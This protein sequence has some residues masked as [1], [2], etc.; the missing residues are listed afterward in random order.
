MALATSAAEV[1]SKTAL[2]PSPTEGADLLRLDA[3]R[4]LDDAK[5]SEM[6]QFMTPAQIARLMASMIAPCQGSLRVLDA[7]AGLGALFSAVVEEACGWD[8]APL[9]IHVTAYEI[10]PLLYRFL[11]T[12]AESCEKKCSEFG[13]AFDAE[14]FEGDFIE[15]A[16][17]TLGG[18]LF[19]ERVTGGFDV[20]I[21][22]PPY[23]KIAS[24]SKE[25]QVLRA[26]GIEASNLYAGFLALA[27]RLLAPGGQMIAITPRSFCN[28]PYFK[29]FRRS[30]FEQMTVSRLHVFESRQH[31]FSDDDI[32][33][34]NVILAAAKGTAASPVEITSSQ[35][36]DDEWHKTVT[37]DYAELIDPDDSGYFVRVVTDETDRQI[38]AAMGRLSQTLGGLGLSVSTGRVV[39]FRAREHLLAA[40]GADTAPLI[41]PC[42]LEGGE[43]VWP[44][45]NAK[46]PNAISDC[47]DTADLLVPV[48][49][50]VLTKRFSAKE[51]PRR[52]VA[53]VFEPECA[54]AQRV[55]FE[56]HL[57]Y[58]HRFGQGLDLDLASGLATYLNSTFVDAYFRQFNGHT[59]VNATD[60]RSLRYPTEDQLRSLGKSA[61]GSSLSQDEIDVLVSEELFQMADDN[62]PD[63]LAA[64]KRVDETVEL[65]K[66]LG[67]PKEQQNERSA[68]TLLALLGVGPSDAWAD[69][70]APLLGVTEMM[71]VFEEQYGKRYAPNTRETVR[72]FTIHQFVQAGLVVQ[73]P[74]DPDRPTNSPKNVY[75]I[76]PRALHALRAYRSD[77]WETKL[78]DYLE[79]AGEL[80][81]VYAKERELRRIPVV[82]TAGSEITLSPGGQNV[83]VKKIVEEF[84]PVFTPGAKVVY[85]GDTEEKWAYFDTELLAG[86][87]VSLEEHGKMPDVVVYLEER[88]WLVLIEAV[89]SHGPVSP[90]RH[91]ELKALF[92]DS[93]A[94]LVFVT[95]FLDRQTLV[96]YLGE[97]A[98]ETEVWIAENPTHLIHFNG[99][100]FLGPYEEAGGDS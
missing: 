52:I 30:F 50:Y 9:G 10:D 61:D 42:H 24:A 46:K 22:N 45:L 77:D 2:S 65:L 98:W 97:I 89:T 70:S 72:R 25:R 16:A 26:A 14:L 4:H 6:G 79:S 31:A 47:E 32:L 1:L 59:Q 21:L 93:T 7:G 58:F 38:A 11:P 13:I 88:N 94:G 43:V 64:K 100:R 19:G 33:Q 39:D 20:A 82:L 60:L 5:R 85:V 17:G 84:C 86:L 69:A 80:R 18:D 54:P 87:G 23:R 34:E 44:K 49:T 95:T 67:L 57:N 78:A 76:E 8:E 63:A 12:A 83:L 27:A 66:A 36:P 40:P 51:E 96:R 56:N 53:A 68:L 37:V 55:G 15:R 73:N 74:D 28:G 35:G 48:E 99:E 41:Y 92:S 62:F 91:I 81:A 71:Q 75:Q 90:K 3:M 29:A